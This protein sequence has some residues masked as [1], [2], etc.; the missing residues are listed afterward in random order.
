[1]TKDA[2]R[3]YVRTVKAL[4]AEAVEHDCPLFV[5]GSLE[6]AMKGRRQHESGDKL[7]RV[8]FVPQSGPARYR[9]VIG[10]YCPAGDLSSL[11]VMRFLDKRGELS[12][13][14]RQELAKRNR[15]YRKALR[16]MP[17]PR[18]YIE[19]SPQTYV[20]ADFG[21]EEK[22]MERG[23]AL[24]TIARINA[25]MVNR[26]RER[27]KGIYCPWALLAELSQPLGERRMESM[28]IDWRSRVGSVESS[29]LRAIRHVEP[30][31][32]EMAA[33]PIDWRQLAEVAV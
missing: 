8:E 14:C 4:S 10:T 11:I 26:R 1:M 29:I 13:R 18:S 30:T 16:A 31:P 17:L 9:V 6:Q 28:S 22:P 20:N 15:A 2:S 21:L 5:C 27:S 12:L 23:E 25:N 33:Y 19:P 7:R 24:A 3:F 32:E